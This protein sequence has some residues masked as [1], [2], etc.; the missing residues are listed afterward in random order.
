MATSCVHRCY[1]NFL[2]HDG[3][4]C[5]GV[6]CEAAQIASLGG[7]TSDIK[8]LCVRSM[9]GVGV[10]QWLSGQNIAYRL[11]AVSYQCQ[12][13]WVVIKLV[14]FRG[15][16][17]WLSGQIVLYCTFIC[18]NFIY[19]IAH[20]LIAVLHQS[21]KVMNSNSTQGSCVYVFWSYVGVAPLAE[22]SEHC[23]SSVHC[24]APLPKAM[25]SNPTRGMWVCLWVG[26]M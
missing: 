13:L 26:F 11:I 8:R 22:W 10:P 17:H 7:W 18:C 21:Q 1:S 25:R 24:L 3:I 15:V 6:G 19:K 9:Y 12:R 2:T 20:W 5:R 23:I 16:P 4:D 14:L